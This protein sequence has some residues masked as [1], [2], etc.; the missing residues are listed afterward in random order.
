MRNPEEA[1]LVSTPAGRQRY[2]AAIADGI[3]RWLGLR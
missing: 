2:A 3:G 1:R